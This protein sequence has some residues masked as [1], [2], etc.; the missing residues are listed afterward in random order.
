MMLGYILISILVILFVIIILKEGRPPSPGAMIILFTL[1][2]G[3]VSAQSSGLSKH[4]VTSDYFVKP[5]QNNNQMMFVDHNKSSIFVK[6]P[7]NVKPVQNTSG[8][9]FIQS[10]KNQSFITVYRPTNNYQKGSY[11]V[12]NVIK[13]K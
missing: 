4:K 8:T 12:R 10:S 6:F 11:N 5:S 1:F 13:F 9:V 3:T 2:A 7:N